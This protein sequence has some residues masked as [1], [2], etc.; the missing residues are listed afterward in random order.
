MDLTNR[1]FTYTSHGKTVTRKVI[2]TFHTDGIRWY[3]IWNTTDPLDQHHYAKADDF[4]KMFKTSGGV[5]QHERYKGKR[6][7]GAKQLQN[8]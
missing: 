8:I 2:R 3:E 1:T 7:G 4:D 5:I 6:M